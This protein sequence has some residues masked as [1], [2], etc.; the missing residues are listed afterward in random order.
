M[1]EYLAPGVFVEE[2]SFRTKSIQPAGTSTTAFVGPTR[3]GPQGVAS[4]VIT[5]FGEYERIY[6]GSAPLDFGSGDVP[7]YMA[8]AVRA[9]FDNGGARLYVVRVFNGPATE[10]ASARVPA[11]GDQR[12]TF[13]ARMPG[14]GLNGV[15]RLRRKIAPATARTLETAPQGSLARVAVASAGTPA[16]VRTP[17]GPFD[18]TSGAG[19]GIRVNDAAQVNVL[20]NAGN[21][22][23]LAAVTPAE[24]VAAVT[25][26]AIPGLLVE[27]D[28]NQVVFTTADAGAT[29]TLRFVGAV[30]IALG[31]NGPQVTGTDAMTETLFEKGAASWTDSG[32]NTLS[33]DPLPGD[34][35]L[36]TLNVEAVDAGGIPTVYEKIGFGAAHPRSLALVMPETP[37]SLSAAMVTPY[38]FDPAGT[39]TAAQLHDALFAATDA[40]DPDLAVYAMAGGGDG[41][42]PV[43]A[44]A[45]PTDA[46]ISYG[47]ALLALETVD[48]ISIIAAPGSSTLDATDAQGV[49]NALISHAERMR[50]RIAVLDTDEGVSPA[51]AR[52]VRARFDSSHAAL[53]YPWVMVPNPLARPGDDSIPKE[54]ALP[55]SGFICGIYARNDFENGVWKAPA[56][57]VVRGALRF[58]RD[59]N[60]GQQEVLN[61]EGINCLRSFFG[62]GNQV[63]G[64]RTMSSDPEWV[65]VNIRRYFNFLEKSIDDSTQWAVFEPNGERLWANIRETVSSFLYGQW[66]AGAL[67]GSTP[68]A[69]Y[70]VRCDRSTM[71]QD[72]FDNGRLICEIGVAA[73]KPAEFVI[74]RIGQKTADS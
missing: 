42:A 13:R 45:S 57:E 19:L 67:M 22:A 6:G 1:P 15:I 26:A 51:E 55:P 62:R 20:F 37:S 54:L 53:Y 39:P 5:S 38:W 74:F 16:E 32:G 14:S 10:M 33:L 63:W 48:D 68:E 60:T 40:D 28:G 52:D 61:P 72:D 2:T 31:I 7:N 41:S 50:Y 43:A 11:T 71:T 35:S 70:F 65:Y 30:S 66:R 56:N 27:V 21:T 24:V 12:G 25:A 8:H 36:V 18:L 47:D 49:Q 29:R 44:D 4:D 17:D 34:T 58:E 69:A 3:R 23:D 9:Y 73:L 59:I 64:A 46:S